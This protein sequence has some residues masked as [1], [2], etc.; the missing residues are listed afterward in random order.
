M[1]SASAGEVSV[2]SQAGMRI[3]ES[4]QVSNRIRSANILLI[5]V[6]ALANE[7]AKNLVLAGIGSLTII[8]HEP[9]TEADLD[10]Q[11]FLEE[12]YKNE[13]I[14]K[15]GKNVTTPHAPRNPS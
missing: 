6:K 5:T 9:V 8:D 4:N 14:I 3:K 12:A 7:V 11:F 10:A 13:D 1:G 15:Q 2:A